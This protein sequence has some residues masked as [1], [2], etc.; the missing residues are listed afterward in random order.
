MRSKS[1]GNSFGLSRRYTAALQK[2]LV[3]KSRTNPRTARSLGTEAM[4]VGLDISDLVG[5]HERALFT[6]LP[7]R[8]SSGGR[9][10]MVK[11]AAAFCVEALAPFEIARRAALENNGVSDRP[12]LTTRRRT[13]AL[14]AL[15]L[16]LRREIDLREA[17]QEALEKSERHYVQLLERSRHMQEHLRRLS[18]ELL[19]SQEEERKR[20]SRE[21]H[22][23]VG[24]ILTAINVKLAT[25]K[26]EATV[27]TTGLKGTISSTQRLVERSMKTVHRFARELRPPI[28]DD[29]GL[30]PALHSF[31]KGFTKRT[32]I[33]VDFTAFVAVEQLSG[34]KRT[35]LYRVA[36]E[37]FTN[38]EKHAEASRVTVS[39]RKIRGVVHMEIHDDG[40]S[41]QVERVLHS[42]R[43][44]R[45]GLIGMQERVE[46]VGGTFAV[47]SA[48][49]K[50]TTLSAQIPCDGGRGGS[51]NARLEARK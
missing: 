21:L 8:S 28:L 41:F 37:A 7:R 14:A 42:R 17:V 33:P 49:G 16:R 22:D 39:I 32:R 9:A 45:L 1:E 4:E 47:R 40:R 15:R 50:G 48:P 2:H 31:M 38:V 18:H 11:L 3:L 26:K 36:Q 51:P 29:L 44:G 23:E 46:M 43:V 13:V 25:L 27:N 6:L 24:Q 20:I 10:G 12:S 30:I 19:S 35:V 5:I 34:D